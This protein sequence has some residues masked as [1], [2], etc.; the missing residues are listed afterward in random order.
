MLQV[1]SVRWS[2][3]GEASAV[4]LLSDVCQQR[5]TTALRL[6]STRVER[7]HGLPP[8]QR[9]SGFKGNQG[10]GF[11]DLLHAEQQVAIDQWADLE[12]DLL[13]ASDLLQTIRLGWG[14]VAAPCR[15][16]PM[17]GGLLQRRGW[18]GEPHPCRR[19]T[20]ADAPGLRNIPGG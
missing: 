8:G 15:L 12:R 13:A 9:Q 5:R 7:P 14:A 19:C 11:R 20:G 16:A 2:T 10:I 3:G 17:V 4:A 1:A 18:N 6:L